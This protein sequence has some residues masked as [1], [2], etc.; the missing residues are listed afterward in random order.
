MYNEIRNNLST[1]I[2][3]SLVEDLLNEYEEIKKYHVFRR[4]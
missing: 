3:E 4:I 1:Q 2:D